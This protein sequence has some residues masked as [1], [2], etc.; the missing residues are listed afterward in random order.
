MGASTLART[1]VERGVVGKKGWI[2]KGVFA[3]IK[4]GKNRIIF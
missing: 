4:G 2:F 1:K 3:A